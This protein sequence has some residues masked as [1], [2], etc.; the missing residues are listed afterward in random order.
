MKT[1]RILSILA[2]SL[3]ITTGYA[4]RGKVRQANKEFDNLAYV[5]T[6]EILLKVA[7]NGYKTVDLL[8]KLADSFYFNNQMEEASKWYG[9]L[10]AM[11]DNV[12]PEYYFRYAQALKAVENYAES[13]KWMKKFHEADRSDLRGRAFASTVDYLSMIDEASRDFEVKNMDINTELSDFGTTQYQD[14]LVFA[15]ARGGG[16]KYKWNEQPFLDL[17]SATK[18]EDGSYS[19]ADAYNDKVNTKFHES[20]AAF[21]PDDQVMYFTR[22]NYY[23]KKYKKS[24]DGTNR[25]KLFR[26]TLEDDEWANIESV[27]FNSDEYSVAHPTINL[28]GTKMYFASDM[29]GTLGKSDIFE[30]DINSDGTLGDPVNLGAS[31]NTEGHETFPFINSEG[32]LYF[33]SNGFSGLGGLDVFVIREFEKRRESNQQLIL[34]NVGR[35]INSPM[36]DFAYYENIGTKEGFFTSNRDGGKGDDDIYSFIIPDCEQIVEG[37]VKDQETETP[38]VGAKVTLL[39]AEG[40]LLNSQIV[41]ADGAYKFEELECEKEYLIRI[42]AEDYETVE[43]RFTTPKKPQELVINPTLEKDVKGIAEGTDLA[44]TLG[45][46]IIYFD[47]DKY[48][49]RYDAE[50]ELQKVLAVMNQYPDMVVDI[51][52]HTDCRARAAYNERLSENRA[53]STRDYLISKGIAAERLTAKGYGESQLVNDCGCEPTNDSDCTEEQHQLNRRSE[54]IIVKM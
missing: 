20:S 10:M 24:E 22:N 13:D 12:D 46:P 26:A 23:N 31:V 38:I 53:Q 42:E 8:Q 34:E 1:K 16:K 45:I 39:D 33:S 40:T 11:N 17:F 37:I 48:D 6:S 21:T 29:E 2:L 32:D 5:K 27:H 44:E 35:P 36:D 28:T 41:G 15:S 51:R 25:L 54:F 47:F 9:E 50:V 7:E 30:V 3:L 49:I 19:G 43:E 4:Q 52:S 14:Q 18:Q